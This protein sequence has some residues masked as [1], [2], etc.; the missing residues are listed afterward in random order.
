[1]SKTATPQDHLTSIHIFL[2]RSPTWAQL[3]PLTQVGQSVVR[4][5]IPTAC[6]DGWNKYYGTQFFMNL[7]REQ[8]RGLVIH[9]LSHQ[10][11][12]HMTVYKDLSKQDRELANVAMDYY[13]NQNI[14]DA[15]DPEVAMPEGGLQDDKYRGWSI[16]KIFRDLQSSYGSRLSMGEDGGDGGDGDEDG[17]GVPKSLDDHDF[18][19][20]G[21]SGNM[22]DKVEREQQ[23][24]QA[25]EQGKVL[26]DKVA[27]LQGSGKG[28]ASAVLGE[29]TKP[30]RNWKQELRD[31]AN[32]FCA[33]YDE[34][35]WRK[36][37]RKYA[38]LGIIRPSGYSTR[39]EKVVIGFDT[40]GSCFGGAEMQAFASEIKAIVEETAPTTAVVAYVDWDVL[41]A[42]EF[43]DGQFAVQSMQPKGGGGTDL[44]KLYPWLKANGHADAQAIIWLTDGYTTFTTPP[45]MPVLWCMTTNVV[46]PY[47]RTVRIDV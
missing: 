16:R 43:R 6:T 15:Q 40:S 29:L 2:G 36:P 11:G 8:K 38:S 13:V 27:K 21:G 30:Q 26:A 4:D 1:M 23:I 7:P 25:L 14:V 42:Q 28:G 33:G 41:G 5:D 39:V 37:N 10:A 31:F 9:E 3:Y 44:E 22:P 34:S 17:R 32:Q 35:T 20:P 12:M 18:D 24:A 46:A 19:S 45:P 47:G